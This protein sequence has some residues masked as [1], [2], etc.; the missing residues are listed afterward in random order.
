MARSWGIRVAVG[1]ASLTAAIAIIPAVPVQAAATAGWHVVHR[2]AP[3]D[4]YSSYTSIAASGSHA[5][6]VGGSGVAGNGLPIAAYLSHGRWSLS[7]VPGEP[8]IVG[9]IAAVS[10]DG[11]S[12]AW[13]VSPGAVLHWQAGRWTIAKNWNVTG[14]PPG[15][16]KSG[17]TALSPRNVWVFG[18]GPFGNGTWH[19]QGRKWTKITG[20]GGDIFRA[21]A[22]SAHDIWAIGGS[23]DNSVLHYS[24]HWRVLRNPALKGLQFGS[25]IASSADSVWMTASPNGKTGLRLLHLHG[26][27]W[28][29]YTPP[30]PLAISAVNTGGYPYG[31]LSADGHGGFWLSGYFTTSNWLLHFSAS[32]RWSRVPLGRDAV[33]SIAQAR[34]AGMFAVGSTPQNRGQYPYTNA[35]IWARN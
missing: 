14:G 20:P 25:I 11:P 22:V 27:R 24:G 33:S 29:A 13:A 8:G 23:E 31:G 6:A 9:S 1:S 16:Y 17:I 3:H 26:T 10:A 18:G 2:F 34:A 21:S 28:T 32:G 7:R 4:M 30:W 19:L 15:P 12:D 5:W 35:V